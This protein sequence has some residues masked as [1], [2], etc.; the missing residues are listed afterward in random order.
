MGKYW[1]S[2]KNPNVDLNRLRPLLFSISLTLT[3]LIVIAAF[4]W[5]SVDTIDRTMQVRSAEEFE[6]LMEVPPTVI[7][8]PPAPSVQMASIVEVPDTEEIEEEVKVVIDIDITDQTISQQFTIPE[9]T[10]MEE[11]EVEKIFLVVEQPAAPRDGLAAFYK[12]VGNR[13][14]YPAPARRMGIEGKVFVEF[15]VER[16]GSLTQFQVVKGIGAGCDEEAVRVIREA[17][18]WIPGKQRGKPVRQRMVLPIHF[19]LAR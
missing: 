14:N 17:P 11:E 8:P 7:P 1:E 10:K 18:S 2:K 13:I 16:D 15:I 5:R 4:E 9:P 6:E 3:M 19:I 12:D